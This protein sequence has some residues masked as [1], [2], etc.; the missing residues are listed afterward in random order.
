VTGILRHDGV[1]EVQRRGLAD[2]DQAHGRADITVRATTTL[3]EEALI[4]RFR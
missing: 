4:P 1:A 2:N 3:E